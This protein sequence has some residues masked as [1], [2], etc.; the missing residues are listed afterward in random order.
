VPFLFRITTGKHQESQGSRQLTHPSRHR[1]RDR[2]HGRFPPHGANEV[3][4]A[5]DQHAI[6]IVGIDQNPF[7]EKARKLLDAKNV[8]YHYLEYGSSDDL[9]YCA[10]D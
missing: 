9:I 7:P 5:I 10:S 6:V 1:Q 3:E 8:A 2:R 4:K